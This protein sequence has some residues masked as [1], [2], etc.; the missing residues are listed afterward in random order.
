VERENEFAHRRHWGPAPS[1]PKVIA[2]NQTGNRDGDGLTI[3]AGPCSVESAEQIHVI[4]RAMGKSGAKYLR[5]GIYRAGTY[6]NQKR[7]FGLIDE[8][9]I[10]EFS[11]A[12]H[13]NGMKTVVEVLEYSPQAMAIY[14]KYGDAYQVGAR[15]MQNYPLLRMLSH[16]KRPVFIKRGVGATIDEFLGSAEW[17]LQNGTCDVAL[18]ERGSA[19]N[20]THVRWD[21]SISM[22]P[23]VKA[24][25]S[26]PILVDASHGTGRRDLVGPMTMAGIAAGADGL[27]LEAHP[28][29]SE[30]ISDADQA[31]SLDQ[32]AKIIQQ[33]I[34]VKNVLHGTI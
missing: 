10:A 2:Y 21:L 5:G 26:L 19:T 15:Q 4:A 30:S 12:A 16:R 29:P 13:E 1:Y 23:A 24:I 20:A 3:L 11:R 17:L 27:L 34:A 14:D 9:L 25:T 33:C 8:A 18:I 31:V 32:A 6:P 7:G 22:I 28:K